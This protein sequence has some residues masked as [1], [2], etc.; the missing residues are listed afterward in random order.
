MPTHEIAES[1][2]ERLPM[3]EMYGGFWAATRWIIYA[4]ALVVVITFV[5]GI[6]QRIRA[7]RMGRPAPGALDNIGARIMELLRYGIAQLRVVREAFPG[8]FHLFLFWG[9]VVLFIGTALTVLDE[10]FYRL[11]TGN[12][13]IHGGFYVVF[14][15]MLD[16]F[17]L[18]ALVGLGMALVR[19]YVMKPDRLDNQQTDASLITWIF[20][21]L[22]TGFLTEGA[23]IGVVMGHKAA[24]YEASSFVGY[25]LALLFKGG[26]AEVL[27][28]LFWSVHVLASMVF[29]AVL[30]FN[31]GLHIFS[32]L[33][34]IFTRS[35]G[36]KA[37]T[38][39]I[40]NMMERME[41]GEEVEMGYKKIEDL[42]W[43]EILQTDACT[44]CGRCQDQCPAY[45]TG[46][47]LSPKKFVQSVKD[48]WLARWAQQRD[49]NV[50]VNQG[51]GEAAAAEVG[52]GGPYLLAAE[53]ACY[54]CEPGD[55]SVESVVLWDCT[56]CMACVNIC[57][58]FVEHV[59][60]INQMRREL[61]MEF[62]DSEKACKDFFKNMD[63]NANPWGMNPSDKMTWTAELGV[64][65]VFDNPDYEYLYWVGC[66]G[67]YDPRAIKIGK[68]FVKILQAA[69][70][71]FAVLGE[72]ELCCG[73][74]IRRL[75][76]EAS[77]QALVTMFKTTVQECEMDPTFA[78]KK[79]VT[80]CPHGFNTLKHEYPEFGFKWE[81]VHHTELLDQ[82]LKSGKIKLKGGNGHTA[83]LHD[84]CFL[85]R[86]N[87]IIDEPRDVLK[88]AGYK[89]VE[90]PRSG[91]LT[92]CCG[93]GG[94]R[95]WLE[96][97]YE[98]EK[99][100]NRINFNRTDE[101]MDAGADT[102]IAACPLCM[103]MFDEA[104]KRTECEDK[105]SCI[106]LLDI[107]EAV[108]EKLDVPVDNQGSD[109]QA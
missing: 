37:F 102:I 17:G 54:G 11:I 72:M 24:G 61:A 90:V 10:D 40:P 19:R 38:P 49:K 30:P 103:M 14:S 107:A 71:N 88:A 22:L 67:G 62:D 32:T 46:K 25:G 104:T 45:N 57:P 76:N 84:S 99:G 27:H 20:V 83:V 79:V 81:V 74:S 69:G 8:I 53:A 98:P 28:K 86:Y 66:M 21:I 100:I 43:R 78:G 31:K 109:G 2:I 51:E 42:T 93:G 94:G 89:M 47:H 3:W 60:L 13:F 95:A 15:F 12:K 70:V 48:H 44:R 80:T 92:F 56:N 91:D 58:V 55:A 105:M 64:P 68:A 106:R 101:L 97:H 52:A 33:A 50:E 36:P 5:Y 9:F 87:D 1:G 7:Y 73:D 16:L 59:P 26:A 108:A 41:A 18:L 6:W 65:T 82:L 4:L 29:I 39:S 75:G 34:N 63:T 85:A 96:E 77:F 35:L 23:R